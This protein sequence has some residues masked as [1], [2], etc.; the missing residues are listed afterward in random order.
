MQDR[1]EIRNKIIGLGEESSRKSYYPE[2]Q[3]KLSDLQRFRDLLDF[4]NEGIIQAKLSD[5][6]ILEVNEP[7]CQLFGRPRS[8]ML[9]ST[10]NDVFSKE[11]IEIINAS[12]RKDSN[13]ND[14]R[15]LTNVSNSD[16]ESIDLE[17]SFHTALLD[18][19]SFLVF[20]LRDISEVVAVQKQIAQSEENLRTVFD[21]A[22]DAIIVHH[23]DGS[24]IDVNN[25]MLGLY[26]IERDEINKYSIKDY[27]A[28]E[29]TEEEIIKK[30]R[31]AIELGG[32]VFE[33]KARRPKSGEVFEAEV[34]LNRSNWNG[35]T[36]L[37]A[38][39]RDITE[40]KNLER[41]LEEKI[42]ALTMPPTDVRGY[43]FQD[44]FSAEEMQEIQ[45]A[46]A[47]ACSVS[48]IIIDTDGNPITKK[49][50]SKSFCAALHCDNYQECMNV[51]KQKTFNM[52]DSTGSAMCIRGICF[53]GSTPIRIGKQIIAHWI[54]G[55]APIEEIDLGKFKELV[56]KKM[57]ETWE[58]E[59][60]NTN[61]FSKNQFESVLNALQVFAK[62]ISTLATQNIQQAADISA[63]QKAEDALIEN[64]KK[65][66]SYI[67]SAPD[68]VVLI[69]HTGT[70]LSV[71]RALL[72]ITGYEAGQF[73]RLHFSELF[74][75][76]ESL[77]F[78]TFENEI[79]NSNRYK[80][81][82]KAR[83]RDGELY[84][85]S[86]SFV[87]LS[88]GLYLGFCRDVT[89]RVNSLKEIEMLNHAL[90]ERVRERTLQ[91]E[92][93][94]ANLRSAHEEIA[95]TLDKERELS[96]LK[97]KFISTVSHEYRTPLTG[98]MTST[99]LLENFFSL[100]DK[101]NFDKYLKRIQNQIGYMSKMLEDVLFVG[102]SDAGK[103]EKKIV[104]FDLVEFVNDLIPEIKMLD[105]GRHPVEYVT[106]ESHIPIKN[107]EKLFLQMISNLL[108]NACK[109]SPE[110]KS[111]VIR[112]EVHGSLLVISVADEGI[113]IPEHEQKM[114]FEPFH[115]FSNVGSIGGSGLGLSV[116]KRCAD[117]LGAT[118]EIESYEGIGTKV[119]I[120][121]RCES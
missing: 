1:N 7:A 119:S 33:W 30:M 101:E 22:L 17:I 43:K 57:P 76:E 42:I 112:T 111:V 3:R 55:E 36:V 27:S 92:S 108:S 75:P 73:M 71:N 99:F 98:I 78:E 25:A 21:T 58:T 9:K 77:S 68:G 19:E 66:L 113:G 38:V 37:V 64:E 69:N 41:A 54:I 74:D 2:L 79:N 34:G 62:Q 105:N 61:F 26:E 35:E 5:L 29:T 85:L 11:Q 8:E 83:R 51:W 80:R 32:I 89:E 72:E 70:F 56:A 23:S 94:Y 39:I 88:D 96:E 4:S 60:F 90:E 93:A 50:E 86:L 31:L 106:S 16:G 84:Y 46:F 87:K 13:T 95:K 14:F 91:L 6:S 114:L 49:S 109:Y 67:E 81:E 65:L 20:I 53:E 121:V 24:I 102:K 116:V 104:E 120:S 117:M 45:D 28:V 103:I 97:S 48:S 18:G 52:P 15:F 59:Y 12:I 44:V 47:M 63:R 118:I 110:G 107:D 40:R 115:R 10:I 82:L 100:Q